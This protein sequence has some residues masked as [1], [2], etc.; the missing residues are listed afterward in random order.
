MHQALELGN[1]TLMM[2]DGHI[3][4]DV[5]GSERAGM[6]VDDLIARFKAG[7]G[8]EL[9]N[10]RILFIGIKLQHEVLP[11]YSPHRVGGA[12]KGD[13]LF[14][15]REYPPFDPPRERFSIAGEQLEELRRLPIALPARGA[16]AFR[17]AIRFGVLPLSAAALLILFWCSLITCHGQRM[18]FR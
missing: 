7:A 12:G 8:H 2:A 16:A 5:A 13:T 10:D 6:G 3:V 14:H 1:R 11:P 17:S 18:L 9:D 15:K 4:L